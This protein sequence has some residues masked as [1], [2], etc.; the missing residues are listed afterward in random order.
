ME[1]CWAPQDLSSFLEHKTK[2]NS[3]QKC[4]KMKTHVQLQRWEVHDGCSSHITIVLGVVSSSVYILHCPFNFIINQLTSQFVSVCVCAYVRD[5]VHRCRCVS[6]HTC[7]CMHVQIP[8]LQISI[9]HY[10]E[11]PK[12]S[13][14]ETLA[15][16]KILPKLSTPGKRQP[17]FFFFN[18]PNF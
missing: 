15:K 2:C 11:I 4:T 1:D 8:L 5:C 13:N 9:D 10:Q 7:V 3:S 14:S 6:I 17:C 12:L 18:N 16:N